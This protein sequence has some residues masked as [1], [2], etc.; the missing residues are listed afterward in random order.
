MYQT[1]PLI[2]RWMLMLWVGCSAALV[3]G[4][5]L[6][7][8]VARVWPAPAPDLSDYNRLFQVSETCAT[9]CLMG[10]Q[11]GMPL[12]AAMA[13]LWEH[14]WVQGVT[15][16]NTFESE[17]I[18]AWNWNGRQPDF[19]DSTLPGLMMA[20]SYTGDLGHQVVFVTVET[21]LRF[22]DLHDALGAPPTGSASYWPQSRQINYDISYY[23]EAT[24]IR[25]TLSTRLTCPIR[26]MAYFWHAHAQIS[27]REGPMLFDYVPPA[28]LPA[29]CDTRGAVY[30]PS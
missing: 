13:Q 4:C 20:R 18:V 25:T 11:P 10:I 5:L 16:P 23:D 26:L 1:A 7:I 17:V 28:A 2:S 12:S 27:Q 19:I 29:L 6:L 21:H 15:T 22:H 9:P 24:R 8:G 30:V 3:A 14:D